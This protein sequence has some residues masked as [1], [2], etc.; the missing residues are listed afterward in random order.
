MC[1]YHGRDLAGRGLIPSYST[2]LRIQ[3]GLMRSMRRGLRLFN[4]TTFVRDSIYL[5]YIKFFRYWEA[6]FGGYNP[7]MR[8]IK[9]APEGALEVSRSL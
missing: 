4:Q 8:S 6:A 1:A 2:A 5:V 9:K 3:L 7:F